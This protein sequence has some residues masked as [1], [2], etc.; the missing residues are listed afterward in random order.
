M[1][2]SLGLPRLPEL[3][4]FPLWFAIFFFRIEIRK[5][6]RRKKATQRTQLIVLNLPALVSRVLTTHVSVYRVLFFVLVFLDSVCYLS[7]E[8]KTSRI[9]NLVHWSQKNTRSGLLEPTFGDFGK[10]IGDRQK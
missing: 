8:G 1:I 4:R 10:D 3:P 6:K 2:L 5:T 9:I 7:S